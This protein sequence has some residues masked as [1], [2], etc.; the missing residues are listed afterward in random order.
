MTFTVGVTEYGNVTICYFTCVLVTLFVVNLP[1]ALK[2]FLDFFRQQLGT[3]SAFVRCCTPDIESLGIVEGVGILIMW[4]ESYLL[5]LKTI[6]L[7]RFEEYLVREFYEC[8]A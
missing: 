7:E 3:R 2:H 5:F 4:L 8:R 1:L 6:F